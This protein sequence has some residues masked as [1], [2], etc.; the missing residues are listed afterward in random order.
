[1]VKI[2]HAVIRPVDFSPLAG[3][4]LNTE[5]TTL[6]W[7]RHR[8]GPAEFTTSQ[9]LGFD[10]LLRI[11]SGRTTHM[12]D[13]AEYPL[14]PADVLWV[15][16]G[17]VQHWGRIEDIEGTVVMFTP[18]TLERRTLELL[19]TDERS[20]WPGAAA[21]GSPL[22]GAFG[23]LV[24]TAEDTKELPARSEIV[25]HVLASVLL[26][27]AASAPPAGSPAGAQDEVYRWFRDEVEQ[28]FHELHKVGEYAARLGYS[29]RTINRAVNAR[30]GLTAKQLVDQ[31]RVLEAKRLLAH[32]DDVVAEIAERLGFADAANFSKYFRH[33]TGVAP[34]AFR[35]EVRTG[36]TGA[37]A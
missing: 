22:S 5:V 14:G 29:A 7:I 18:H 30:T 19:R 20:H 23:H 16:A 4:D 25:Q 31:R 6:S 28:R 35:R 37:S 1:M 17:Q 15:R 33:H 12:V 32:E 3:A 11:E 13:F 21:S 36:S 2:G 9:R 10:L 26:R 8:S 24:T 34:A 27:L